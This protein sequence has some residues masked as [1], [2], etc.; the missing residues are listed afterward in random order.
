MNLEEVSDEEWDSLAKADFSTA[1]ALDGL[2]LAERW[3]LSSL[4][5]VGYH[6]KGFS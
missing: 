2:P 4:H 3:I 6:K 1:Q 5:Q